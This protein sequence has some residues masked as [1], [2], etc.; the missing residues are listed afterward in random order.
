MGSLYDPTPRSYAFRLAGFTAA[1]IAFPAVDAPGAIFDTALARVEE[2]G[3]G[4]LCATV[5][6]QVF[7]RPATPVL[8]AR[9]EAWVGS[10]ARFGAEA[11]AGRMEEARFIAERRNVARDG[12]ALD[13]MFEEAR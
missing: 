13:S 9:L 10:M 1:L 12:A 4:I 5:V 6:D 11:L 2:I 7:P 3:L 8:L